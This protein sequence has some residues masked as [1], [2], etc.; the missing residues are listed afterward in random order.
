QAVSRPKILVSMVSGPAKR[1]LASMPVRPSAEKLARSSRNTR[2][3]SSQSIWSS[4]TVTSPSR[5]QSAGASSL[6]ISAL[7]SSSRA[8]S[9][10]KR[11]ASRG[12]AVVQGVGGDIEGRQA[13]PRGP[14]VVARELAALHERPVRGQPQL[15]QA[16]GK[17]AAGLDQAAQRA[18][19]QIDAFQDPPP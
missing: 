10:R 9:P 2:T 15:G 12:G 19:R 17:A 5:S 6:P 16:A 7:A 4:A 14:R 3:S 8:G 11:V 1:R 18:R 13:R